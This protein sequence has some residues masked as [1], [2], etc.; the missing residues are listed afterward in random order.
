MK[1]AISIL[2]AILCFMTAGAQKTSIE[3]YIQTYRDL[4]IQ[5]MKRTGVPAAI[6]LAQGIHETEGGNSDLLKRSNNHFGIKCKTNWTGETV[7]HDDDALGECFR[8]YPSAEDSYR[9]H[10]NFLKGSSRYAFLFNLKPTDYKGWA[11]GLKRA[12]YATNPRYPQ[13]IIKYIEEYGLEEYTLMALRDGSPADSMNMPSVKSSARTQD[14]VSANESLA[15]EDRVS[16]TRTGRTLFNGLHAVWSPAGTS[17]LAIATEHDIP[18]ARLLDYNDLEH[19]G[20][21]MNDEWIYLEKKRKAGKQDFYVTGSEETPR[22]IAQ[23]NAIQLSYLLQYNNSI[24]KTSPVPSG[25]RVQLKP[26]SSD[27]PVSPATG[28]KEI[29][30]EVQPKEG[31]LAISRKYQVPVQKIRE[32]NK[33]E[34]DHLTIGQK[35]I[36][37]KK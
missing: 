9:D 1:Q 13:I 3:D 31:L 30:H 4:A 15:V 29:I 12:G 27:P 16:E 23:V 2:L 18:L 28:K 8:K 10:S 37:S 5:E 11:Y 24:D 20:L 25:T 22:F 7:Y 35:L 17:L 21:L 33:L 36:I 19:D 6:K 34:S 32:L 14:T 26:V